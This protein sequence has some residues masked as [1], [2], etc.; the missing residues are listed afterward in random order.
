[1]LL[2]SI[3]F[4]AHPP[5]FDNLIERCHVAVPIFHAYAHDAQCQSKYSP[6]NQ[7]G[8]GLIDGENVERL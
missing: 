8:F 4:Q 5:K 7:H 1:M 6:R 2:L 3:E